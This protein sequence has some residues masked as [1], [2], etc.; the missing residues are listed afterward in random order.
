[1][2]LIP[3]RIHGILDYLITQKRNRVLVTSIILA[4]AARS[5]LNTAIGEANRQLADL[6]STTGA[7]WVDL[8]AVLSA[9]GALAPGYA[10]DEIHLNYNGYTRVRDA[11]LPYLSAPA[12]E[13]QR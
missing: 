13:T 4:T 7:E 10:A 5:Q 1:M 2:N 9:E 12:A 3:T 11:L 8:N 6:A